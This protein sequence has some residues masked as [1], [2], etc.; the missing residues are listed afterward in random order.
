M[1]TQRP[2]I[3]PV[4]SR[5]DG[6]AGIGSEDRKR[7]AKALENMKAHPLPA[8]FQWHEPVSDPTP[9]A[10]TQSPTA[11]IVEPKVVSP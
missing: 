4:L 2:F 3:K 9:E 5:G 10:Q 8:T 1:T 6:R 7:L 11:V